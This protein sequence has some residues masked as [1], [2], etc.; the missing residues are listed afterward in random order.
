MRGDRE[1]ARVVANVLVVVPAGLEDPLT[2]VIVGPGACGPVGAGA[3]H[4]AKL[5]DHVV[6]L[7]S[8]YCP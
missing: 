1:P 4:N 8:Q 7:I 2:V 5:S 3:V 6:I